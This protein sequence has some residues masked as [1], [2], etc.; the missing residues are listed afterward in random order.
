MG[1]RNILRPSNR[2]DLGPA[3][4]FSTRSSGL[5][6]SRCNLIVVFLLNTIQR[7]SECLYQATSM[8]VDQL[9]MMLYPGPTDLVADVTTSFP[10][11]SQQTQP[12]FLL[13]LRYSF[14]HPII[15]KRDYSA[16]EHKVRG[17]MT[18]RFPRRYDLTQQSKAY[19]LISFVRFLT[20]LPFI[21]PSS[22][23]TYLSRSFPDSNLY[24][25]TR[26]SGIDF[27]EKY[28]CQ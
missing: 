21:R 2:N 11:A 22:F 9:R 13:H 8:S 6:R 17:V 23:D 15:G 12:N 26:N 16:I 28:R 10:S 27:C 3:K 14:R 1:N 19:I 5:F 7:S 25:N 20:S 18:L 24:S 4:L